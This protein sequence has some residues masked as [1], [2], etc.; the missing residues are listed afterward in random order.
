M[1]GLVGIISKKNPEI[2]KKQIRIMLSFMHH[3]DYYD[4]GLYDD[5]VMS[6][7]IGWTSHP[8]VRI[9]DFSGTN[10]PQQPKIFLSGEVLND[11]D[12]VP[13]GKEKG[14]SAASELV[15]LYRKNGEEWYEKLNGW[16]C[17]VIIDSRS[18][19]ISLF[20]DRYGMHRVFVYESK[21]A[22]YFS[23]EAKAILAI[24]PE[25][26]FDPV[27]LGE[28]L[29]CGCTIGSNS[30]YK[31]IDVLPQGVVCEFF[32][33]ELKS[34]KN[35]FNLQTWIDQDKLSE[36]DYLSHFI[37]LFERTT[38]KYSAG[39][40][41]V[42][43]SLTGGLDTRMVMAC[44]EKMNGEFPCYT[45]GSMYRDTFDVK[46]ARKI[47]ESCG[48]PYRVLVL[49]NNFLQN[50]P[51]YMERTID[52]SGGYIG[53]SGA[54]ELCMNESARGI[55]PVRLT[56]NYGSELLRGARAFK[57]GWPSGDFISPELLPF[58]RQARES[59]QKLESTD[60]L[61]FA[62][63]RQAPLQGYGRLAIES[64]QLL[65]RTPFMDNDLV[66]LAF[67]APTTMQAGN[68]LSLAVIAQ[69]YSDLLSIP[70]DRGLL[71]KDSNLRRLIRR[72]EREFLFKAEYWSSHGMPA[73]LAAVSG[74]GLRKFLHNKFI[75]QHKFQH[76][77]SWTQGG[78][79]SEY[80]KETLYQSV[81]DLPDF[82]IKPRI[83]IMVDEHLSG[84]K[85]YLNEMDILL[86]LGS[87]QR[88]LLKTPSK[89][90]SAIGTKGRT[91]KPLMKR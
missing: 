91:V 46:V 67:K 62:L 11:N 30:L 26:G 66:Q 36:N 45:F 16:F 32:G 68:S 41:P 77:L 73:W 72:F 59:F 63:F 10:Q 31:K 53:M 49:G 87:V 88:N 22:Y 21:D 56:G 23:S 90:D 6:V 84:R 85:N 82:F 51:S 40:L 55:A 43:I 27:G 33:G 61:P 3:E 24:M 78:C 81:K 5:P 70:T 8:N 34:I 80:L 74:S 42:G 25:V 12:D 1:P 52:I 20:N 39:N 50:F 58:L 47:A 60:P 75:G 4:S 44:L 37:E 48:Q 29:T 38:K 57:F 15:D 71:G 17:G 14:K 54:A 13:S 28:L 19:K 89:L 64:S 18:K 2:C 86:T 76:F 69:Y 65:P 9:S 83:Q 35:Y 7:Y 79:L